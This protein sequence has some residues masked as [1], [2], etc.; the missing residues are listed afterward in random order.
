LRADAH[1]KKRSVGVLSCRTVHRIGSSHGRPKYRRRGSTQGGMSALRGADTGCRRN[2]RRPLPR[3]GHRRSQ[4]PRG[5]GL[6]STGRCQYSPDPSSG[7][8]WRSKHPRIAGPPFHCPYPHPRSSRSGSR[9]RG[10]VRK[11]RSFCRRRPKGRAPAQ[12]ARPTPLEWADCS[13]RAALQPC[14]D[15]RVHSVRARVAKK[16]TAPLRASTPIGRGRESSFPCPRA[17][18]GG[19]GKASEG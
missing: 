18:A 15:P 9:R 1:G 8:A 12:I 7:L 6:R 2:H 3:R 19:S 4:A 10:S 17:P 14:N 11:V 5:Q 13:K 16:W